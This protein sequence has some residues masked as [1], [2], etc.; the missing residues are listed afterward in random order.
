[1]PP[2]NVTGELHMGHALTLAIEDLIIR[3]KRMLGHPTLFL[4]GS[5][6]AGIA[7]QVVVEKEIAKTGTNRHDL[8]RE[9]FTK[10]VWGKGR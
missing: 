1:M 4:P 2:P 7:T 8:G 3:W 10:K 9:K 5:D 6:H